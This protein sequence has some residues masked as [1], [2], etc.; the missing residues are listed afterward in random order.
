M[1]LPNFLYKYEAFTTQSLLNLKRQVI[2][3][4]SPLKFNDPYDCA[5]TPTLLPPTE[6]ETEELRKIYLDDANLP[7][8]ARAEFESLDTAELSALLFR[9]ARAGFADTIEDFAKQRGVACFSERN[10]DLLMWSH[11]GG[12]YKGLCLEFSTNSETFKKIH[13]VKYVTE[14][15]T[16]GVDVALRGDFDAIKELFCTKSSA[17]CYEKEWRAIHKVAGTEFCYPADSLTGVYFGPDI[18]Q[19]SLE[20]VCLILAG[21]NENVKLWRGSRSTKQFKV[22]FEPFDY[23][24]CI[25]AKRRGLS[26]D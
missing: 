14:Q 15:P 21:Q 4:S 12:H 25:D 22:L 24:S 20:I 6:A 26:N 1:Q 5:L 11:Y 18:D 7:P 8:Q 9:S 10:D 13:Q 19:Q 23:I 16:I 3:F 2:Y 17:W